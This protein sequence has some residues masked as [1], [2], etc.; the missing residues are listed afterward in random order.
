M[1]VVNRDIPNIF[2]AIDS[3]PKCL[4]GDRKSLVYVWKCFHHRRSNLHD[5]SMYDTNRARDHVW[6]IISRPLIALFRI[7]LQGSIVHQNVYMATEKS[8]STSEHASTTEGQTCG[9][10]RYT[11]LIV[12]GTM[13]DS[14]YLGR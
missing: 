11:T 1:S 6:L 5:R 12:R 4:L 3:P 13:F 7:F 10:A 2:A 9:V 14:L 8:W